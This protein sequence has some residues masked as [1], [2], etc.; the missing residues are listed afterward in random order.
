VTAARARTALRWTVLRWTIALVVL[1]VAATVALWPRGPAG[2]AP[3]L[4]G[5]TAPDLV[6]LRERAALAPCPG[7]RAAPNA[8]SGTPAAPS[9]P[10]AA[11][12]APAAPSAPNAAPG[13]PSAPNGAFGAAGTDDAAGTAAAGAAGAAGAATPA[14]TPGGVLAG[15]SVPCLG[16]GATVP[17]GAA[18]AGRDTLL[19]VWSHT[20]EP[21]RDELP[22]LQ[23]Y[24]ARPDAV[25]VLG[26]QVDGSPQ[27][28]LALLTAL[29][30]HLPSVTDQD[31]T[32]RAALDAPQ[33]LPLSYLV[34]PDGSVRMVNPPVV[35]RSA[36]EVAAAVRRYRAGA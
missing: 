35:F 26:V 29:G 7:T 4:A 36:D 5:P 12:G 9:A 20:C 13:A 34:S 2:V 19:N 28:G 16:D 8:A 33:V 6:T 22:A 31:G 3:P 10:N 32:L 23:E 30:V 18:L 1:L 27:A 17:L 15:V 14:V 11:S 25:A 21:C 24:A